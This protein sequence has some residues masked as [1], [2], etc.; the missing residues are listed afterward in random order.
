[1]KPEIMKSSY[2]LCRTTRVLPDWW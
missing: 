2:L 1:V